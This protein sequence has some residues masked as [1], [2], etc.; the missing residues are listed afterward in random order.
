MLLVIP[1]NENN[2]TTYVAPWTGKEQPIVFVLSVPK[3]EMR[4][5]TFQP[6]LPQ[7]SRFHPRPRVRDTHI[8][9]LAFSV[10]RPARFGKCGL[11]AQ[12]CLESAASASNPLAPS[13][14]R[15][16]L[17]SQLPLSPWL[18]ES[19]APCAQLPTIHS[20]L[21]RSPE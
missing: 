10:S 3:A 19:L 17:Y 20:P 12:A 5:Q 9:R 7:N 2:R 18:L 1:N 6:D 8:Q 21:T 13:R 16:R 11:E 14:K 4:G 15:S